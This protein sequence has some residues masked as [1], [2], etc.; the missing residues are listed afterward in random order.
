MEICP[1]CFDNGV[2]VDAN[3]DKPDPNELS[4]H[5]RERYEKE[6]QL[7]FDDDIKF[8]HGDDNGCYAQAWVWIDFAGTRWDKEKQR[9]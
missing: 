3:L 1:Q 2:D 6:G 4:E 7:E 5:V 9:Q 8:S